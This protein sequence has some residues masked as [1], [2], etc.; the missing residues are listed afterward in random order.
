MCLY[1]T[2]YREDLIIP[3]VP[4]GG[5]AQPVSVQRFTS[6]L[7]QMIIKHGIWDLVDDQNRS[8]VVVRGRP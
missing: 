5:G 4:A 6:V 1:P 2:P 7:V 3:G 8:R